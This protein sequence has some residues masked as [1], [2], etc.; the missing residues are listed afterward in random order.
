MNLQK[1]HIKNH[2]QIP[3]DPKRPSK[4]EKFWSKGQ[5]KLSRQEMKV[6]GLYHLI[7]KTTQGGPLDSGDDFENPSV[8]FRQRC[9]LATYLLKSR[10]WFQ[11]STIFYFGVS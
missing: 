7:Q 6:V 4:N 11:V 3:V 5:L 9:H 8:F 10:W 2:T 1:S